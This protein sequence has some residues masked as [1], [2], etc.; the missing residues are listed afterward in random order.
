MGVVPANTFVLFLPNLPKMRIE[1]A[2][3]FLRDSSP[4]ES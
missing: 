1:D 4:Q 2:K 3:E